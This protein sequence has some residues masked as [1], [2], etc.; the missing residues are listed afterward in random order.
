MKDTSGVGSITEGIILAALL[1]NK[2]KVLLPFGGS[3]RYDLLVDD[4]DKFIRVQ[5][6]TGC[7]R[8]GV[9]RFRTYSMT[10][11][12]AKHYTKNEIDAFGVYCPENE[13]VYFIPIEQC[14]KSTTSLRIEPSKSIQTGLRFAK[15]FEF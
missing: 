11:A 13:K 6:K 5:C 10:K 2:K 1:R 7:L 12:G 3:A 8:K 9:I 14:S 4:G 15:D